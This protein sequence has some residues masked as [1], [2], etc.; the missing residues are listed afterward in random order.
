MQ[1]LKLQ[2]RNFK[3]YRHQDIEFQDGI[4]GII[5][6][7]G[8]GKSTIVDAILFCLYGLKETRLDFILSA[9]AGSQDKA[10]VRLDFA[11]R[12]EE[13][14]VYRSVD[15]RKKHEAQVNQGGRLLAKG[16]SEVHAALLRIIRM[17]HADFR[18]TIF[19]GQRELLAL[20]EA[21]PEERKRWFRRVLGIDRIKDE[22]GEILRGDAGASREKLL[23]IEGRLKDVSRDELMTQLTMAEEQISETDR[24]IVRL[25]G[26]EF[27]LVAE[28][29]TVESRLHDLEDR[30]RRDFSARNEMARR[31][32]ELIGVRGE[33]AGVVKEVTALEGSRAEYEDLSAAERDFEPVRERFTIEVQRFHAFQ[34]LTVRREEKLARVRE[35]KAELIGLREDDARMRRDEE[36]MKALE[37]SRARWESGRER[38]REFRTLE[39]RARNLRGEI[40]GQEA[41]IA[42]LAKRGALLRSRLGQIRE[43][44]DRLRALAAETGISA[45][46]DGD[47]VAALEERR[48]GLVRRE[49]DE[50]AALDQAKANL[51]GLDANLVTLEEQGPGGACPTCRQPLG[52]RHQH[53]V[54]GMREERSALGRTIAS[55]EGEISETGQA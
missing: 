11:V 52:D 36:R 24:E 34:G 38:L 3:R 50:A 7:N 49:A 55:L 41:A 45:A 51:V 25:D 47:V 10:E 23:L 1:L 5:G 12:G 20:V 18:H 29:A 21:T 28:K 48:L 8:T 16:V 31:E 35:S 4:T 37:P 19:S 26:E 6:N 53:L 46:G 13:Y 40:A 32:Q 43:A 15:R 30:A 44:G 39:E 2:M 42:E 17:G 22:G 9:A 54:N 14:Q 27:S 33:I